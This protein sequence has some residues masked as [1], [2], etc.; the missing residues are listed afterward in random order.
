MNK[1]AAIKTE[2][3]GK[4]D[5]IAKTDRI[6]GA[7]LDILRFVAS[8]FILV[9]HIHVNMPHA[10]PW[11]D[12]FMQ[13]GW[14]ATNFFLMLSGLVMSRAYADKMARG[15][16]K[17]GLFMARRYARLFPSHA[18]VLVAYAIVIAIFSYLGVDALLQSSF[19]DSFNIRG[20]FEQLF[21]V[22]AWGID[23]K[24]SWNIPTWTLSALVICYALYVPLIKVFI[25]LN[26]SALISLIFLIL[27][28]ANIFA[29]T[30]LHDR[31]VGLPLETSLGRAIPFFFIGVLAELATR[32]LVISKTQYIIIAPL[33]FVA[34]IG[35]AYADSDNLLYDNIIVLLTAAFMA[36]SS[37]VCFKETNITHEIGQTSY[38]LFLVHTPVQTILFNI[39]HIF[40]NTHNYSDTISWIVWLAIVFISVAVAFIFRLNVDE[41]LADY[42]RKLLNQKPRNIMV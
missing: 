10:L 16:I 3:I 23:N 14:L 18:V 1:P 41:P 29:E 37:R 34:I 39:F 9:F 28:A 36:I 17:F 26:I 31:L 12:P 38:S 33:L 20:W 30:V 13:Q 6:G 32:K 2:H 5:R 27:I 40:D 35:F 25:K 15:D 21:F 24:L 8:L 42:F 4:T 11:L 7:S 19:E 22:Y